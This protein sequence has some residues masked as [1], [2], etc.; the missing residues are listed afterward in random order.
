MPI[1]RDIV[2]DVLDELRFGSGQGVQIHLETSIVKNVSRLY[3][4]FMLQYVWRDYHFVNTY[5]IDS[6]GDIIGGIVPDTLDKFSNII[7]VYL[8]NDNEPLPVAPVSMNPT[9]FRRPVL[10]PRGGANIFGILP[11]QERNI[12][13]VSRMYQEDD[14]AMDDDVPFYRDVL[15]LGAAAMLS[16]KAGTNPELTQSL[17]QQFSNLVNIYRT[18][19]FQDSYQLNVGRGDIPMEWHVN[20]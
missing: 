14:F 10:V 20:E 19:E 6:A 15:G 12:T 11:A 3:R 8:E 7:A 2:A 18:N 13:V 9:K 16:R 17:E 1:M 5:S 4:T